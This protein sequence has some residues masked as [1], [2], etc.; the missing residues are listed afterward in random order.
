MRYKVQTQ[1][2]V[3]LGP[4]LWIEALKVPKSWRFQVVK[5]PR[6]FDKL[7]LLGFYS[8]WPKKKGSFFVSKKKIRPIPPH[9]LLVYSATYLRNYSIHEK[10]SRECWH[11]HFESHQTFIIMCAKW[12]FFPPFWGLVPPYIIAIF[13]LAFQCIFDDIWKIQEAWLQFWIFPT[14][15]LKQQ[16]QL[17]L[18]PCCCFA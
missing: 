2:G 8:L 14:L 4:K 18:H 17:N 16:S 10:A 1:Y 12:L 11:W 7:S 5:I 3:Y 9:F 13:R 15:P 6:R